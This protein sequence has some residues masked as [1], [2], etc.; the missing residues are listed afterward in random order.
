[1]R[2]CKADEPAFSKISTLG[3]VFENLPFWNPKTPFYVWTKS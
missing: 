3:T 2:K 1:M